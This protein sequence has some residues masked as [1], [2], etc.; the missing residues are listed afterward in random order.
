VSKTTKSLLWLAAAIVAVGALLV[1]RLDRSGA[2]AAAGPAPTAEALAVDV[3]VV[4]PHRLV[5]RF[6][7]VG[8]IRADE[9]VDLRS[10]I[11]GVLREIRFAEG[12]L[13]GKG[14]LLVQID[15]AEFVADRDRAE[16]RSE[17]ARLREARQQDLLAQGLTSQEEYD[18]AL[19]ELRVLQAELR[20]AEVELEKTRI[21]APFRGIIGL[22]SVS[23]GTALTP[24]TRIARLQ[25]IDRVKVEFSV[26]ESHAARV[27]VG[28]T[29]AF[30]VKGA[31]GAHSAEIYALEPNVDSETR[32]LRARARCANPDGELLPGAFADV[33]LAINEIEDALTVPAIAVIPELGSKKV[34]VVEQGKAVPRLV[35]TGVRTDTEVQIIRGLAAG[36]RVIVSAIQ[37][38]NSGLPVRDNSLQQP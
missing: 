14:Q 22:R 7:T 4:T 20:L 30:R 38:L 16:H 13:V 24:Q 32:S 11:S 31:A 36:D 34:F 8:T 27:R 18:L 33:E 21:R 1:P 5:E 23:R 29:I 37:R 12:S 19:S 26:P 2:D 17:L 9:Q 35:E 6:A 25:K 15:E 3:L 10:E 28:E